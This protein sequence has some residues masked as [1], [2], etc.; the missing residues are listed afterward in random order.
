MKPGYACVSG[1]RAY[2]SSL[3]RPIRSSELLV[4]GDRVFTDVVLASRLRAADEKDRRAAAKMHSTSVDGKEVKTLVEGGKG[5]LAVLTTGVWKKES[6]I[7]R[8]GEAALVKAVKRWGVD[9]TEERARRRMQADY[10]RL[11]SIPKTTSTQR[12]WF[13]FWKRAAPM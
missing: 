12:G 9:G 5:T 1:V 4:V 10:T 11:P 3:Q 13:T 2:F 7:M 6:M 8:M